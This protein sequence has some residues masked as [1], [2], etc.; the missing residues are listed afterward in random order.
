M[1]YSTLFVG[2]LL[3]V[4]V[5]SCFTPQPILHLELATKPSAWFYG[6][7]VLTREYDSLR[8][9][10]IF[11]QWAGNELVFATEIIN[12]SRDTVLVAPETF[13]YEAFYPDT[14]Q[15]ST[16]TPA[17]DPEREI[18]EIEKAI[19]WERADRRN[20]FAFDV[21]LAAAAITAQV[22]TAAASDGEVYDN[23]GSS[24]GFYFGGTDDGSDVPFLNH[25][26]QQ[27]KYQ[28][29]RKTS[30]PPGR[31]MRGNVVFRDQPGAA[32]YT[33]YVQIDD[34]LLPFDYRKRVIQP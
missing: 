5:T 27:W 8:V 25:L 33:V 4:T 7:E 32:Q 14:S 6:H 30:L 11:E 18:L 21:A 22:A 15:L 2:G 17:L 20:A 31:A 29:L 34:H 28:T 16:V 23:V 26:R 13:F 10:L 19:A 12:R 3:A 1:K 24:V 9:S